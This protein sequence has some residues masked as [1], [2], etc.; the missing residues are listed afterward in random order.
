MTLQRTLIVLT[1]LAAWAIAD[2]ASSEPDAVPDIDWNNLHT[3]API[4]PQIQAEPSEDPLKAGFPR[5]WIE[6]CIY[7]MNFAWGRIALRI[8]SEARGADDHAA[9]ASEQKLRAVVQKTLSPG[10]SYR[11]F[12]N[13]IGCLVYVERPHEVGY[14]KSPVQKALAS[15]PSLAIESYRGSGP[16][17]WE[18]VVI[19]RK[20]SSPDK[21]NPQ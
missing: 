13:A 21:D 10:D 1:C 17:P 18:F 20:S 2:V 9:A 6:C 16:S 11:V 15:D 14:V 8:A 5:R 7:N 3:G 19:V 12:C 4:P